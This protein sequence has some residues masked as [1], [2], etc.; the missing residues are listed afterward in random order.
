MRRAAERHPSGSSTRTSATPRPSTGPRSRSTASRRFTGCRS[1]RSRTS[2]WRSAA[3]Q[4]PSERVLQVLEGRARPRGQ[5][6]ADR[7]EAELGPAAAARRPIARRAT[8]APSAHPAALARPDRVERAR[9]SR[10]VPR[11]ARLDLAEDEEARVAP[12]PGRALR[13]GSGSCARRSRSP[14]ARGARRRSAR[15]GAEGATRIGRMDMR[16]PLGRPAIDTWGQHRAV[17]NE[18]VTRNVGD[19]ERDDSLRARSR[20]SS[21]TLPVP[22]RGPT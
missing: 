12:R 6:D 10:R 17:C 11:H 21:P 16:R 19:R 3:S 1:R 18:A 13:S 2:S 5:H 4:P 14:R 8:R 9:R 15:R 7:V 22:F 20:N